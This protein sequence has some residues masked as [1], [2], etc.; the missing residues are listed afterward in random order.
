MSTRL[1][2][3]SAA[4]CVIVYQCTSQY[5]RSAGQP[6]SFICPAPEMV[7]NSVALVWC[8]ETYSTQAG[9]THV[10]SESLIALSGP[11]CESVCVCTQARSASL[12]RSTTAQQR[13]GSKGTQTNKHLTSELN[14]PNH[15]IRHNSAQAARIRAK[16][17]PLCM[18]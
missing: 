15:K 8:C 18:Q 5:T 12:T 16:Q 2:V 4:C 9:H 11:R 6:P 7:L 3:S 13:R 17:R 10:S 1:H 14:T